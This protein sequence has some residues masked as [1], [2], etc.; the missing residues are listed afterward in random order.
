M[1]YQCKIPLITVNYS[2]S[3]LCTK[4]LKYAPTDQTRNQNGISHI[5]VT[6]LLSDLPETKGVITIIE[7]KT[8][9]Q[10]FSLLLCPAH[11]LK[12]KKT[13][14]Q[15][16]SI[17]SLLQ[18][19]SVQVFICTPEHYFIQNGMLPNS[20]TTKSIKIFI[21]LAYWNFVHWHPEYVEEAKLL[22]EKVEV[23]LLGG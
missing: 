4:L 14:N 16:I 21:N 13:L 6:K 23:G 11:I 17:L 15:S 5:H 19:D 8:V 9:S 22:W 7:N 18:S 12:K 20:G 3:L 10:S 1:I 2:R